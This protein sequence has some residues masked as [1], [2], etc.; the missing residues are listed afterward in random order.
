MAISN[1]KNYSSQATSN[2][3]NYNSQGLALTEA[4]AQ[5]FD[6]CKTGEGIFWTELLIACLNTAARMVISKCRSLPCLRSFRA[7]LPFLIRRS[8][9]LRWHK[10]GLLISY[11]LFLPILLPD[12]LVFPWSPGLRIYSFI[13]GPLHMPL[14]PPISLSP[15]CPPYSFPLEPHHW[16]G[17]YIVSDLRLSLLATSWLQVPRLVLPCIPRLASALRFQVNIYGTSEW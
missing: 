10:G 4:R 6:P 13:P 17:L 9:S 15:P 8:K 1:S 2:Y 3:A 12:T 16:N 5:G 7:F 11:A 14:P